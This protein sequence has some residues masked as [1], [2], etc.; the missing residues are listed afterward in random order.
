MFMQ[1]T[2]VD[3]KLVG[4]VQERMDKLEKYYDK[5]V[6]DVYL[7]V[8]KTSDKENKVVE[9]KMNV[10]GDDFMVKKQCK[11]FEE[12]LSHESLE[13]LLV[14]GKKNENTYLIENFLKNVLIER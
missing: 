4:Y 7:K 6:S 8:E 9:I 1:L 12:E 11:T 3:G 10:P 14:K 5:V 13:R 2:S